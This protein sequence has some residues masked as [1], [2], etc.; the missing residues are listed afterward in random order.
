MK[1]QEVTWEDQ[2]SN[3]RTGWGGLKAGRVRSYPSEH[4]A[5]GDD[6][7]HL[8]DKGSGTEDDRPSSRGYA[9]DILRKL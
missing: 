5:E 7:I 9:L 1:E 2:P 4:I 6:D 3:G 8:A